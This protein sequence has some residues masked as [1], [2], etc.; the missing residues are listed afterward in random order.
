MERVPRPQYTREFREHAVQLFLK[1]KL[2]IQDAARSLTMSGKTLK[3]SVGRAR[4][5]Q[6]VTPGESRRPVT[7][8]EAELSRLKRDLAEER[9]ERDILEKATTYIAKAQLPSTRS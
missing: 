4:R 7:E 6:L 9:M 5:G 1:Q 2:P 8:L 3:N